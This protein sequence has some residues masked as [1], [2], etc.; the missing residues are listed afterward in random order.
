MTD[1][2]KAVLRAGLETL[3]YSGVHHLARQFL[4][5]EGAILTMHRVRPALADE[6]QPNR[7]LEITPEFLDLVI[8]S[9]RTADIDIISMEEVYQRLIS[10]R[11]GRRFVALTFDDGYRDN[12]KHAWPILKRHQVPFT[13]YVPSAYPEGRGELWWL[14]LEEA[15][16]RHPQ[17]EV[18]LDG[19]ES[20]FDCPTPETKQETFEVIYRHI[21]S[22][23]TYDEL[24]QVIRELAFGYGI[25]TARLCRELCMGWDEL[26]WLAADPLVTIGAHTVTHPILAKLP[27]D[28]ARL[29]MLNGA[30]EIAAKLGRM[31]AHFAYPVGAPDAAGS[32]EFALAAGASFKTAV[33]TRAGVLFQDHARHLTALPR[34]SV[35][36]D[37]Q[38]M[39]YLDVL[40]SGA[41]TALLN[42]FRRVA[43]A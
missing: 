6:F 9:L 26:A 35:N 14:V 20:V 8:T 40:L 2:R 29:E 31:P 37:F 16:A 7:T 4:S 12:L 11:H 41:P 3:Y 34:I 5:G 32:R 19:N 28:E 43:A 42:R 15:I 36:G 27:E 22:R 24:L 25:D 13:I 38:Q 23:E 18:T 10:G 39:R 33:T 21:R 30:R 1:R 17:I